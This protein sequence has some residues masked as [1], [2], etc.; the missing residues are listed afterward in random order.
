MIRS[1]LE[2]RARLLEEAARRIEWLEDENQMLSSVYA[3]KP[4]ESATTTIDWSEVK[5]RAKYKRR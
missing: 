5:Q 2:K 3:F 1:R 4:V